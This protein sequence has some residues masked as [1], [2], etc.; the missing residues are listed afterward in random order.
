MNI[1]YVVHNAIS[2]SE[3]LSY[4]TLTKIVM[5]FIFFYFKKLTWKFAFWF[6]LVWCLGVLTNP[7]FQ[8]KYLGSRCFSRNWPSEMDTVIYCGHSSPPKSRS[9]ELQPSQVVP[10]A[11]R[12]KQRLSSMVRFSAARVSPATSGELQKPGFSTCFWKTFLWLWHSSKGG[13]TGGNMDGHEWAL[14]R[15][16][17]ALASSSALTLSFLKG[18][19]STFSPCL[20]SAVRAITNQTSIEDLP[21]AS[22]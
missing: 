21:V 15:A 16:P 13:G 11:W 5:I 1:Q 10:L 12:A 22:Y 8:L 7:W 6:A 20:K 4:D 3:W 9:V 18:S 17:S 19:T 14:S 2:V